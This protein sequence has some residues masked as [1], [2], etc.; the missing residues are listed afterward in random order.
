MAGVQERNGSYRYSFR[1]HGK[2]HFVTLGKVSD[3]EARTKAA[4]VDYLLLRLK[5]RLIQLPPGVGVVEFIQRDGMP[6]VSD[7][8]NGAVATE[9]TLSEF[10]DRYLKTHRESLESRTIDG[11]ELH[12]KHLIAAFGE[13]FPIRR[14]KLVDLQGYVDRR[15]KAK[16]ISG[17]RL[18][19]ATIRKEIVSLR[20]AWNWGTRMELVA[21]RFPNAGLRYPKTAEKPPFQTREQ[22]VRPHQRWIA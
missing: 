1:Y 12:F 20:T 2:Q 18:S 4:H 5:Q 15:A 19:A 14:L 11:I 8:G 7:D 17:T 9:L 6:P 13:H 21:G 22:I 16:G 10:R 3:Q